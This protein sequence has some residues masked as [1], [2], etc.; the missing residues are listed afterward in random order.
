MPGKRVRDTSRQ[1]IKM[2]AREGGEKI[3]SSHLGEEKPRMAR[4][5]A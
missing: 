5:C 1:Q 3:D 4:H 2:E